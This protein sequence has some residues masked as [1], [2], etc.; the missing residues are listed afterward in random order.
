MDQWIVVAAFFARAVSHSKY[1]ESKGFRFGRTHKPMAMTPAQ[2][3][4][5]GEREYD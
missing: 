4:A 5:G 1:L 2:S 3:G